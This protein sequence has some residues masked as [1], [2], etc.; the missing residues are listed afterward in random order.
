M[1]LAQTWHLLK[2]HEATVSRQLARARKSIRED[3]ER[4]MRAQGMTDPKLAR[5]F[6]CA[7]EDAGPMDL[8]E[9]LAESA[10]RK[11]SSQDRSI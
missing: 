5:C 6:E 3:V 9:I 11:K 10:G 8:A 1:T 4:T 7:N 2:E